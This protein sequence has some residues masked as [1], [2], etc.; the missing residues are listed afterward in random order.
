MINI[1]FSGRGYLQDN[2]M[3]NTLPDSKNSLSGLSNEVLFASEL[4]FE[5]GKKTKRFE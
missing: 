1:S 4:L 2:A 3:P 5:G